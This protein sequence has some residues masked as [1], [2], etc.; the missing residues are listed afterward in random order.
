MFMVGSVLMMDF[1]KYVL[2]V[3]VFDEL[4]LLF[5]FPSGC[6]MCLVVCQS[7]STVLAIS[8]IKSEV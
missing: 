3:E 2:S 4:K 8:V 1:T 5:I 7:T 6:R